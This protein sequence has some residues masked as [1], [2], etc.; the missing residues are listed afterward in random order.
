LITG[1]CYAAYSATVL[2][3]IGNAGKTASTQYAL[4]N[5]ASNIAIWWV[6]VV[7]TRF[8]KHWHVEGVVASDAL[9]NIVG[10]VVIGTIFWRVGAFR[11]QAQVAAT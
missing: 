5:S 11:K 2:E 8:E 4:F 3:T 1:L 10:V 9:L 6:G 7:D